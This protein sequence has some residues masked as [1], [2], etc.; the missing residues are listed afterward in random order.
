M[1][2]VFKGIETDR[3]EDHQYS[4]QNSL[5]H[6]N[7]RMYHNTHLDS[8]QNNC[9]HILQSMMYYSHHHNPLRKSHHILYHRLLDSQ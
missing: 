8:S 7:L 2:H 3:G 6:K 9:H 5:N 1:L 4:C